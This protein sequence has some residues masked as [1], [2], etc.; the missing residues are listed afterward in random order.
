MT[1]KPAFPAFGLSRRQMLGGFIAAAAVQVLPWAKAADV[2]AGA[3]ASS[4]ATPAFTALSRY[5][6][7]RDDLNASLAARMQAALQ[8]LNTEFS[9]QA[10]VLWQWVDSGKV[11]LAELNTR[12]KAEKPELVAI[13]GQIMQAWYMGIAGSGTKTRVV[14]YEY[15]L[16][17]QTVADKLKPPTYAYGS[18]GSWSSNPTKFDLQLKPVHA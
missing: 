7:E 18:Y 14:A 16:N 5:L 8:S 11:T 3:N 10:D 13:P 1:S 6:T 17:A 9:A 15:A 4:A 12:L 2:L